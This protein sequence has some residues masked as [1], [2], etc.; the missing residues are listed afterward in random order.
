MATGGKK[1]RGRAG[2]RM[3]RVKRRAAPRRRA[4]SLPKR[5]TASSHGRQSPASKLQRSAIRPVS[6]RLMGKKSTAHRHGAHNSVWRHQLLADADM[7]RWLIRSVGEHSIHVI[8]EFDA[9]MSDEEIAQKT[10]VRASDVRVVLNKLHSF[11]LAA[12]MRNRDRNS[13]WYSYVWRLNT[14]R[15]QEMYA[16]IKRESG[17]EGAVVVEE[18]KAG[19]EYYGCQSC[20]PAKRFDFDR[21]A[22]LLF[23]CDG[24]GQS[25]HYL[26]R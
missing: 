12:Y 25:L 22:E 3:K 13:G 15:A 18:T 7:R 20:G 21:A 8:Q 19:G 9:Q 17:A 4:A 1:R 6:Q 5:R 14:E 10:G 2:A 23:R 26:E 11:G 24:C 16:R